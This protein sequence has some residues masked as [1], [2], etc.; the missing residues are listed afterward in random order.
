MEPKWP[1]MSSMVLGDALIAAGIAA[2]ATAGDV[3]G[4]ATE[5]APM[6]YFGSANTRS[7]PVP[8]GLSIVDRVDGHESGP[9]KVADAA[10]SLLINPLDA[11]FVGKR[12]TFHLGDIQANETDKLTAGV[13]KDPFDLTFPRLPGALPEIGVITTVGGNG[14]V[15]AEPD[16]G[17]SLRLGLAVVVVAAAGLAGLEWLAYAR[18]RGR[19]RPPPPVNPGTINTVAGNGTKVYFGDSALATSAT[20]DSPI[21]LAVDAV[22]N[23]LVADSGKHRVRQIAGVAGAEY[24]PPKGEPGDQRR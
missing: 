15:A 3:A 22:G 13:V 16:T 21:G 5:P 20:L 10:D 7:E 1:M 2:I 23:L 14:R 24:M 11:T 4:Q 18:I 12:V 6:M 17:D 19:R 9:V 8:D